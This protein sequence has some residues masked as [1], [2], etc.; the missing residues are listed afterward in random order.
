MEVPTEEAGEQETVTLQWRQMPARGFPYGSVLEGIANA[1]HAQ[2]PSVSGRV[3]FLNPATTM[4]VHMYDDRGLDILAATR[5][6]L[7]PVYRTFNDWVLDP[8]REKDRQ[9][10]L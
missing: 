10:S 1:D 9:G 8:D 6:A 5:E 7:I 2:N 3:Y 4:I